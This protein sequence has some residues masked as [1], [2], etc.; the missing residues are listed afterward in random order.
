ME[1]K[2]EV[3]D[4]A[5]ARRQCALTGAVAHGSFRQVDT[6]VR[7]ALGRLKRRESRGVGGGAAP[8]WISYERPNSPA[9]RVSRYTI[10]S[11]AEARLRFGAGTLLPWKVVR[12]TRELW[13]LKN[14]RIHLDEVEEVG[15]F[16]E[17]E[18]VVSACHDLADCNRA[19]TH[20][21]EQFEPI[22]GESVATSYEAMVDEL[23]V[24]DQQARLP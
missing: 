6:Y 3:R 10:L 7:V 1:F 12:K 4:L 8:E 23:T 19:V 16:I 15:T 11:D 20:L 2:A 18:A 14:V 9:S 5:A 22:L 13:L 17:F 24:T 21:R